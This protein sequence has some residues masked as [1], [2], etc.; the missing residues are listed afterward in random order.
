M[1]KE[2]GIMFVSPLVS[3]LNGKLIPIHVHMN[4]SMT[5]SEIIAELFE[6]TGINASSYASSEVSSGGFSIIVNMV[7]LFFRN[8]EDD[9]ALSNFRDPQTVN[10]DETKEGSE[11]R[12]CS[13]NTEGGFENSFGLWEKI[14]AI[15]NT[16][17][18][19][20][21]ITI[22][23]IHLSEWLKNRFGKKYT[24]IQ[25]IEIITDKEFWNA[26]ELAIK[27]DIA[28]DESKSL[29]KAFG[30]KWNRRFSL[31]SKTDKTVGIFEKI[32]NLSDLKN[33]M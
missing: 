21:G 27:L 11:I 19:V 26:H 6:K 18:N 4:E 5:A 13:T 31:Y 29:L 8:S 33:E 12:V 22:G 3:P 17:G 1:G 16:V 28:G 9:E 32:K 14:G 20:I 24:P 23:S 15:L 7:Q 2:I 25:F 10:T 30:Y